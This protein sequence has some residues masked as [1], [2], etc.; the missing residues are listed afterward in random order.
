MIIPVTS[1]GWLVIDKPLGLSSTQVVGKIRRS[2]NIKKLGHIGTLDPL[3]SGV[4][5]V[6]VRDAYGLALCKQ[7]K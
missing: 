1:N 6:A 3:A 2:Y 7:A 4:F 5:T